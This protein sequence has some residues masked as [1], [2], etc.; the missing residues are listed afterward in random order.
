MELGNRNLDSGSPQTLC[1]FGKVLRAVI[2]AVNEHHGGHASLLTVGINL[3][4]LTRR[5]T[6]PRKSIGDAAREP[7]L[8]DTPPDPVFALFQGEVPLGP[9]VG[10]RCRVEC[11][12]DLRTGGERVR[13]GKPDR[14]E[15]V[16][17]TGVDSCGAPMREVGDAAQAVRIDQIL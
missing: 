16:G 8:C 10:E 11:P 6:V 7:H 5:A 1:H 14:A 9:L 15:E 12:D 17:G 4:I 13:Q 2:Q 3:V